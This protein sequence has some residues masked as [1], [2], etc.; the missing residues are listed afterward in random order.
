MIP[1][2]AMSAMTDAPAAYRHIAGTRSPLQL[3]GEAVDEIRSRRRLV[4]YLVRA[5]MKKRGADTLLGNFWWVLDPILQMAVY[6][7]FITIL[8]RGLYPDYPLFI[9]SA[10]LPWKWFNAVVN[11][12]T[13]SVVSQ[14][15]LIKQMAFPKIVL[16]VSS[17]TAGGVGFLFGLIPLAILVLLHPHRLTPFI[18]LIPVIAAVQYV[19]TLAFAI[20]V[21]ALNVFFRDLANVTRHALRLWWFLSPGL[22]GLDRLDGV[23]LFNKY[24]ILRTI[25]ESNPFAILFESYRSVIYGSPKRPYESFAPDWLSLAALLIVSLVF[26]AFSTMLFKRLEPVFAKVL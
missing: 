14:E 20:L 19:F 1:F 3:L 15:R 24:P 9:F 12:A 16:P 17:A 2:G 21:S 7:A 11:D 5:D 26:L 23:D 25:V 10:I 6:V 18:L 22:Y 13:S 8:A 4:G